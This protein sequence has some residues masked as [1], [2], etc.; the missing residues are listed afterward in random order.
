MN[1]MK[2]YPEK[3]TVEHITIVQSQVSA[4]DAFLNNIQKPHQIE[5]Q[6]KQN[7]SFDMEQKKVRIR[8]KTLLEGTDD[9]K[10]E[11][12]VSGQFIID[13]YIHVENF[14]DFIVKEGDKTTVHASL[15]S[16]L[17]GIIYSTARGIILERTRGT[18]LNGIILPVIN[19]HTLTQN[20]DK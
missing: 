17:M 1:E 3:I 16:T 20:S 19:P 8:L 11:L 12:G 13:F 14:D 2:I 9:D 18:Y 4:S 6:Q 5:I 7:S 10:N 15:G